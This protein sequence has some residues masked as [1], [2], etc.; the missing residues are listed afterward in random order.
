VFLRNFG[1]GGMDSY[2][3]S[4]GFDVRWELRIDFADTAN[5]GGIVCFKAYIVDV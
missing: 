4:C 2:A 1:K 3:W 5:E